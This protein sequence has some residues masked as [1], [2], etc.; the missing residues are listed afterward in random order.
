MKINLAKALKRKKRMATDLADL[1]LKIQTQN[2]YVEGNT[3]V[4]STTEL[5]KEYEQ[6]LEK[7]IKFK[8]KIQIA[9]APIFS[10]IFEL[11]ETKGYLQ[12]INRFQTEVDNSYM[13]PGQKEKRSSLATHDKED[14]IK[15]LKD[16]IEKLQ[17][18]L[19]AFNATTEIEIAD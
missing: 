18:E 8:T 14:L 13:Q 17:D 6:S 10:K 4:K 7:F 2:T 3:P 1:L 5:L 15:A 11:A 12:G 9:N 19:D 16:K